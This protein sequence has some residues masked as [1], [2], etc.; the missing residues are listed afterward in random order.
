METEVVAYGVGL[1]IE[2]VGKVVA[3]GVGLTIEVAVGKVVAYGVGVETEVVA[4][5]VCVEYSRLGSL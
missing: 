2:V 4:V 3:Y 5:G 1:A